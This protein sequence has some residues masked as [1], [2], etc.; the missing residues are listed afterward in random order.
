MP[1]DPGFDQRFAAA[2]ER[3]LDGAPEL[4]AVTLAL[5]V[6]RAHPRRRRGWF[7]W[8]VALPLGRA[9][10]LVLL[11][12]LLLLGLLIA[13]LGLGA[14]RR[15]PAP[16]GLARAGLIAF[17]TSDGHVMLA[18]PDWS[19]TRDVSPS[20]G[21]DHLPTWSPDGTHLAFWRATGQFFSI[22]VTDAN[23]TIQSSTLTP[24]PVPTESAGQYAGGA[25]GPIAWAPDSRHLALWMW[26]DGM[27]RIHTMSSDGSDLRMI[28]DPRVPAI[29]PAWS[30]DGSRI[31][32][33]GMSDF[34]AAQGAAPGSTGLFVMNA[35]GTDV[36]RIAYV[37]H[38]LTDPD[39]YAF[40]EPQWQPGGEL[41]AFHADPDSTM[42]VF[43]VRADGTG[44]R[45]ISLLVGGEIRDDAWPAWS[46]DGTRLAFTRPRGDRR[47]PGRVGYQVVVVGVD[48]TDVVQPTHP[49]VRGASV[50]WSPDGTRIL[51][52]SSDLRH[53][54]DIDL[55]GARPAGLIPVAY[56]QEAHWQRL[57]P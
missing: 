32:F 51:G 52:Y 45:D 38:A 41:I 11:T 6:A 10:W 21:G 44:E 42:H 30:P 46:P 5:S 29:D 22:V 31:A 48:G 8:P 2:Y 56:D 9:A 49:L 39:F 26:V 24:A 27:P 37:S 36:R 53:I 43:V 40:H 55:T 35:D 14:S 4:D 12:A 15:L 3:Y 20:T 16:D 47:V 50:T 33:A 17:D 23:G 7:A 25:P 54:V 34:F 19:A 1:D 57:A 13:T 18:G 28:G